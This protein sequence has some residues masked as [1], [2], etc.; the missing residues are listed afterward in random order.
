MEAPYEPSLITYYISFALT[1]IL[2][3]IFLGHLLM[4]LYEVAG[5]LEFK[6]LTDNDFETLKRIGKQTCEKMTQA[7]KNIC[8]I[9]L[10]EFSASFCAIE[11]PKCKHCYHE[12]CLLGWIRNNST[13]PYCR[14]DIKKELKSS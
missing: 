1:L 13:C 14:S 9:C 12:K 3:L 7:S 2:F 8:P 11:L 5:N 4:Y 6:G 10:L